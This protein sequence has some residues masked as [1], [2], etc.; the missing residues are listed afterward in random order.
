MK[1]KRMA[2]LQVFD[3]D[4]DQFVPLPPYPTVGTG[5]QGPAGP[6]GP[7]GP[8]GPPGPEGPPGPAG[9]GSGGT[10]TQGTGNGT[11]FDSLGS[12]DNERFT[13]LA[14]K[15]KQGWTGEVEFAFRN[16]YCNVQIPTAPGRW[17]GA[18]GRAFEYGKA[19]TITYTGPA[20]S[21]MF[22]L[23]KNSGYSY[24]ANGV[25]RDFVASGIQF[26]AGSDKDFLPRAPGGFDSNY[27][28]WYWDFNNCAFVG[29]RNVFKGW[30]TGLDMSGFNNFQAMSGAT[31]LTLGGS[32]CKWFLGGGFMDSGNTTW[33]ASDLPFIEFSCSKSVIGSAM[34]SARRK[35]YQLKVTYGHNSRCIGTEF[36]APDGYPTES[37][38]VRF[39]GSANN[40]A[41][42]ACSFKG[43]QG[44]Q[45][46][47]GNTEISVDSCM[48]GGNRGLARLENNFGGV[49]LWG[50]NNTFGGA[51]REIFVARESQIICDD[52]RVTIKN[53]SGTVIK[54]ATR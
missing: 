9:S 33:M 23:Y 5:S 12:S 1:G 11:P 49:L 43:G 24:P 40:F 6:P 4:L 50:N 38:Q 15:M 51:P 35:S 27:V 21:S 25:S 32:E 26:S 17:R 29:W 31:P 13:N 30:G 22:V 46:I 8:A 39:N 18:Q 20:G 16:H 10:I 37:Y 48:F 54:A 34:I 42:T 41:F 19:P 7:Q 28:Q 45:G 44:I 47:S 3:P 52:P 14:N 2:N 36:D 53:L